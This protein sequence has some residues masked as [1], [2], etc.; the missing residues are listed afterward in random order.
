[1]SANYRKIL[2][3]LFVLSFAIAWKRYH[4]ANLLSIFFIVWNITILPL[5]REITPIKDV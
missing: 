4:F 5:A 3:K 1:M 2:L